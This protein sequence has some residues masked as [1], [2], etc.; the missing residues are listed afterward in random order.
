MNIPSYPQSGFPVGADWGRA[1]VDCLRAL[2][3]RS[4]RGIRASDGPDGT[5]IEATAQTTSPVA[6]GF[7]YSKFGFGFKIS[8]SIVTIKRG[9]ITWGEITFTIEDTDI[10]ITADQQYIGLECA[11]DSAAII[12]PSTDLATFRSGGGIKRTW[13]Y[14]FAFHPGSNGNPASATLAAVGKPIGNWDIGSDFS[15]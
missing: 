2:R 12:G 5:L 8:G 1:V 3:I 10:E 4:G 9:E 11:Y 13:L 7:D 14:R 15:A 6:I